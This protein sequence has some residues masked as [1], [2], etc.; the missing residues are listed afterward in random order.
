[1]TLRRRRMDRRADS[2]RPSSFPRRGE[3]IK[4]T[5]MIKIRITIKPA[6]RRA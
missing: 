2:V 4:I 6:A 1:V 5:I 3:L